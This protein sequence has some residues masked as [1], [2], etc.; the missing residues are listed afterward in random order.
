MGVKLTTPLSKIDAFLEKEAKRIEN[1]TVRALKY[2]GEKCIKE[3]R[4]RS[5]VE[6]WF[7]HTGNLRS[8]I[9]YV[10]CKNGSVVYESSFEVIKQGNEG[11]NEGRNLAERL[12]S[13]FAGSRWALIVVAGMHYAVTVEAMENK[14]VLA[15]AELLARRELPKMIEKLERQVAA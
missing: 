8:S 13:E 5:Q 3:A 1:L 2:L 12:A 15:S 4:D 7:D 6:S 11:A 14:V 9:G 10:I